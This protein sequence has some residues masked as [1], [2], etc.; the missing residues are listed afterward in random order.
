MNRE[1]NSTGCEPKASKSISC[2]RFKIS[3]PPCLYHSFCD[4]T[5][6]RVSDKILA[7][8][9]IPPL[10]LCVIFILFCIH[11]QFSQSALMIYDMMRRESV[12]EAMRE[13]EGRH[14]FRGSPPK[15]KFASH[16]NNLQQ[17][18]EQKKLFFGC[19]WRFSET[20]SIKKYFRIEKVGLIRS[21]RDVVTG[22]HYCL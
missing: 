12:R 2:W 15:K 7:L 13:W 5:Q 10:L 1:F 17:V 16:W 22:E 18:R 9:N 3:H 14:I 21:E 6:L 20:I 4:I 11:T 8:K 19:F